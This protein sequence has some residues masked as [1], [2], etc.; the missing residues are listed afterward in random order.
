MK[1]IDA[2]IKI[3]PSLNIHHHPF[4][5]AVMKKQ[6]ILYK[7]SGPSILGSMNDVPVRALHGGRN[8]KCG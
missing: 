3:L 6:T 8:P 4:I 2:R 7:T 5:E 1:R